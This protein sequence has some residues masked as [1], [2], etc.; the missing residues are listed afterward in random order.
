MGSETF[1]QLVRI[2]VRRGALRRFDRLKR[3]AANLPVSIE[4]D[5]RLR[6]R[7]EVPADAARD[8]R[9]GERR[10]QPPFT[11]DKAGFVLVPP[12]DRG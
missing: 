4:W 3:D 10:R 7:R 2:F 1:S 5:R 11:W 8:Q 9:Q 12:D 6:D